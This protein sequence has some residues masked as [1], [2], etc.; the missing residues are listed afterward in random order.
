MAER[1]GEPPGE[2]AQPGAGEG[3]P[4]P[5]ELFQRLHEELRLA[6]GRLMRGERL[7][8]TLQTTALV[9]EAYLRLKVDEPVAEAGGPDLATVAARVVRQVLIDHARNRS[10]LKR[11]GDRGRV[12]LDEESAPE[13]APSDD[14]L[15]A[16]DA[17]LAI[18]EQPLEEVLRGC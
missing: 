2:G 3:L 14:Q 13:P 8:H 11:G 18:A 4:L 15:L 5:D 17:A 7:D 12:P 9:H 16:L 6:A 1:F 10:T